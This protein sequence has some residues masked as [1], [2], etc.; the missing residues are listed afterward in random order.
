ML[1]LTMLFACN[2]PEPHPVPEPE[3]VDPGP[4]DVEAPNLLEKPAEGCGWF[5]EDPVV[6][7]AHEVAAGVDAGACSFGGAQS[8]ARELRLR[9]EHDGTFMRVALRPAACHPEEEALPT[10]WVLSS[11]GP[12]EQCPGVLDAVTAA[13]TE[14]DLPGPTEARVDPPPELPP[15]QPVDFVEPAP[16]EIIEEPPPGEPAAD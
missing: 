9:F 7:A 15:Q 1:L 8:K 3:V 13:L 6:Q 5:V 4:A 12:W 14:A 2:T 11:A 16:P 10:G